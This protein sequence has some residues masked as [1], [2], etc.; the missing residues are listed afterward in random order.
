MQIQSNGFIWNLYF[1][2]KNNPQIEWKDS[3]KGVVGLDK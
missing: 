3:I 2:Y 1:Q